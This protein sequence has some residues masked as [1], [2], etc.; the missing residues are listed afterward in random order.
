M[1][2]STPGAAS[3][4]RHEPALARGVVLVEVAEG[5]RVGERFQ[6]RL[7]RF[8]GGEARHHA[9]QALSVTAGAGRRRRS[10]GA[11][12]EQTH[13]ASTVV[14]LVLVNRHD[15]TNLSTRWERWP[16]RGPRCQAADIA[17]QSA[18]RGG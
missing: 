2:V 4:L 9:A 13:G 15:R 10:G 7:L 12:H 3:L 17:C 5:R 8:H 18:R 16:A 6:A 14:T 1:S 11:E